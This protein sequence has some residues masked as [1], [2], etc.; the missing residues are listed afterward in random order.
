MPRRKLVEVR[1][2]PGARSSCIE[3]EEE[4]GRTARTRIRVTAPADRGARG[5]AV[6]DRAPVGVKGEERRGSQ[7]REAGRQDRAERFENGY[8]FHGHGRQDGNCDAY[9]GA[10]HQGDVGEASN[11]DEGTG[12]S[13]GG[14]IA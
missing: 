2:T 6:E 12:Q 9:F 10:D 7:G 11:R 5:R 8:V 4:K 3:P 1:V 13:A 14:T